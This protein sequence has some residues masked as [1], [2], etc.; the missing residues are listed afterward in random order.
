MTRLERARRAVDSLVLDVPD[1]PQRGV[2]FKDITPLLARPEGLTAVIDA[3]ADAGRDSDD[4]PTVDAVVGID[5][6]GFILGAPVAMAL[7]VGFIPVRKAGKLPRATHQVSYALEYGE[8]TLAIH[9]DA[10]TAGQRVLIVDDVLATGGTAAAAR[11]LVTA[12]GALPHALAVILEIGFLPGR[13]AIGDLRL[14][15]IATV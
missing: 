7:G 6:R 14:S 1:H 10:L 13:A 2:V 4:V 12:C 9:Q 11:Q 5:A 3:M 15:S 8:A